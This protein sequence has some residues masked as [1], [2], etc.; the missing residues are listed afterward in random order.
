[1]TSFWTTPPVLVYG[2]RRFE[3][4]RFLLPREHWVPACQMT[5]LRIPDLRYIYAIVSSGLPQE[6]D[7]LVSAHICFS[8]GQTFFSPG[9]LLFC[10]RFDSVGGPEY[11]SRYS[12][13]LWAGRF[14]NLVPV[15]ASFSAPVRSG[16]GDHPVSCT[17]GTGSFPGVKRG[18]RGVDHPSAN[19]ASVKERPS[20]PRVG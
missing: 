16:D 18:G 15:R 19:S 3:Q 12:D 8:Q 13:S 10:F 7:T 14:G 11:R 20:W 17:M 5:R 1:L 2:K 4:S 9:L 6:N